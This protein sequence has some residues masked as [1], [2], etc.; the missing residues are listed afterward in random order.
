[1]IEDQ[2]MAVSISAFIFGQTSPTKQG[3]MF[4][5][6]QL[7]GIVNDRHMLLPYEPHVKYETLKYKVTIWLSHMPLPHG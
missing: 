7:Y 3:H 6:W 2:C 1:V 4:R 5:I